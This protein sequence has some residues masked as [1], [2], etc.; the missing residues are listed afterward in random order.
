MWTSDFSVP[1]ISQVDA[2]MNLKCNRIKTYDTNWYIGYLNW[3]QLEETTHKTIPPSDKYQ[4]DEIIASSLDK[5]KTDMF[6]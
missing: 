5:N 2:M 3:T 6:S 4:I 1:C